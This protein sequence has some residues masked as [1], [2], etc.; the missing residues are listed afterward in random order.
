MEFSTPISKRTEKEFSLSGND[1]WQT[2]EGQG[3]FHTLMEG[4][5]DSLIAGRDGIQFDLKLNREKRVEF[6]SMHR[7]PEEVESL[8]G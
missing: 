5:R 4:L 8:C 7:C 1:L 6:R 2:L 3:A